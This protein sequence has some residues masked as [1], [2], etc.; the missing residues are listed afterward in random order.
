MISPPNTQGS[1]STCCTTWC[2]RL[3]GTVVHWHG[4]RLGRNEAST[5]IFKQ[6]RGA[7]GAG[8]PC[9]E[10]PFIYVLYALQPTKSEGS[11]YRMPSPPKKTEESSV[12]NGAL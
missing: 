12:V 9:I 5:L 3:L 7:G 6:V 4:A 11:K 8:V 10:T 2:R 1:T